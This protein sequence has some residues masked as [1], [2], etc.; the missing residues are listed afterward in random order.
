MGVQPCEMTPASLNVAAHGDRHAALLE[1]IAVQIEL[2]ALL[3]GSAAGEPAQHRQRRVCVV[4]APQPGFA[5]E[6]KGIHEG[7]PAVGL[8]GVDARFLRPIAGGAGRLDLFLG[9][10]DRLQH[11]AGQGV[12]AERDARPL[13]DFP[14]LDN[15]AL[16]GTSRQ[17]GDLGVNPQD[18]QDLFGFLEMRWRHEDQSQI[19]PGGGQLRPQ[20][21]RPPLEARFVEFAG[22]MGRD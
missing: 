4:P 1:H 3:V 15:Q 21:L 12:K 20:L 18:I 17:Q 8:A 9:E 16:A 10:M 7:Q 22:P 6:M 14:L 11:G 2:G 13:L 19:D 5:V